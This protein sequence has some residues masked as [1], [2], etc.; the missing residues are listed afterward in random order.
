MRNIWIVAA[1]AA[2]IAAIVGGWLLLRPDGAER[3][4]G[5]PTVISIVVADN[6]MMLGQPDAPITVV[7]Y[8]S[9][10]CPHCAAFH[11][12][13]FPRVK[14]NYIDTGKVRWVYRDF[15]LDQVATAAAKMARCGGPQRFFGYIERLFSTQAS[16]S[17]AENPRDELKKIAIV[18][19]MTEAEFDACMSDATLEKA[20][21]DGAFA[22]ERDLGVRSTPT[23]FINGAIVEGNQSFEELETRLLASGGQ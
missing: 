6:E 18:G 11:T 13:T 17:T 22:A 12:K 9:L 20:I 15:P 5:E 2:G 1:I 4:D 21:V 23:F 14:T 3:A 16:W 10:T 7:E 19:S 8:A